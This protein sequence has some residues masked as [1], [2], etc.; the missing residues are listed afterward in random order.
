MSTFRVVQV[1]GEPK[2]EWAV[3]TQS[4]RLAPTIIPRRFGSA[5]EAQRWSDR[6]TEIQAD[7]RP[8][9]ACHPKSF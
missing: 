3:E 2:P 9:R 5:E 1:A 6:L 8:G 4:G 7:G